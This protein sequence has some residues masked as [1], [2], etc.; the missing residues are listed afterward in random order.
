ME[1]RAT[2]K[3]HGN[4][5]FIADPKVELRVSNVNDGISILIILSS[6]RRTNIV[7]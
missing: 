3:H 6:G 4:M 2:E 5:K 7:I 1:D